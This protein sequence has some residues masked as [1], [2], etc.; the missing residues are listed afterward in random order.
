[1]RRAYV[2]IFAVVSFGIFTVF[3]AVPASARSCSRMYNE[4]T[5]DA[6]R[7]ASLLTRCL[8]TGCWY[9]LDP[10]KRGCGYTRR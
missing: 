6:Q 1:M 7:C 4:C 8:R 10:S 9:G 5:A 2:A 3:F